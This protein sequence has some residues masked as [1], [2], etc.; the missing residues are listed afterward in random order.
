[1]GAEIVLQGHCEE[2]SDEAIR[3]ASRV[4]QRGMWRSKL[5]PSLCSG[6][7]FESDCFASL[8]MTAFG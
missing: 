6:R 2:H 7:L 8:A 5:D 3:E 4:P 1:M